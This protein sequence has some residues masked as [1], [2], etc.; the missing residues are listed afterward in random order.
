MANTI[1]CCC[2]SNNVR[3]IVLCL[4]IACFSVLFANLTLFSIVVTVKT[5][6]PFSTQNRNHSFHNDSSTIFTRKYRQVLNG[7]E[8][9]IV[10]YPLNLS[11]RSFET[12][13]GSAEVISGLENNIDT[14][15]NSDGHPM[16]P[17]EYETTKGQT[18]I[19]STTTTPKTVILTRSTVQ[20]IAKPAMIVGLTTSTMSG[21]VKGSGTM[22]S[23]FSDKDVSERSPE[24]FDDK[25]KSDFTFESETHSFEKFDITVLG[26]LRIL[27]IWV[28]PGFGIFFGTPVSLWLL[29]P[30]GIRK[31]FAGALIASAISTLSLGFVLV[32]EINLMI[33]SGIRFVQGLACGTILPVMG[34]MTANWATLKEQYFFIIWSH[35]FVQLV[36]LISWPLSVWLLKKQFTLAFI[37]HAITT[38]VLAAIWILFY[39]DRPQYHPWVNGLELNKIVTGKIKAIVNRSLKKNTF[40][41]L[42][43]SFSVWAIWISAFSYFVVIALILQYLPIYSHYI[44]KMQDGIYE[45]TVPFVPMLLM[46]VLYPIWLRIAKMC[47]EK[48][49]LTCFNTMSFLIAAGTFIFLALSP[50]NA[51]NSGIAFTV[52]LLAMV[53]SFYGFC[54]SAVLVG[55]Y[56][57]QYIISYSQIGFAMAFVFVSVLVYFFDHARSINEWRV[58][59]IVVSAVQLVGAAS[60]IIIGSWKPEDWSKQS[61]DPSAGRRLVS[62]DQIDF[63]NEECGILELKFLNK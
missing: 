2:F 20:F 1:C 6:I 3:H 36:P 43:S 28:A 39:R 13:N 60:F 38:M 8:K 9:L 34:V 44:L 23:R 59:F 52:L 10:T 58:I 54:R 48:I 19:S 27:L 16:I 61:W 53:L 5:D 17:P 55:R 57:T 50:L 62:V 4:S 7:T 42:C 11:E 45:S 21:T 63:H 49:S 24:K 15:F 29:K 30:L 25:A 12:F 14:N 46:A 41:L 33:T 35:L 18:T 40:S 32:S 51:F 22:R 47:R 26:K 31:L 56:Y 37:S